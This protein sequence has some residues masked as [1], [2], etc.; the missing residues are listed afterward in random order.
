MSVW[1][2]NENGSGLDVFVIIKTSHYITVHAEMRKSEQDGFTQGFE[3]NR[4]INFLK[5]EL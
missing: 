1:D 3:R 4:F 5:H 2:I